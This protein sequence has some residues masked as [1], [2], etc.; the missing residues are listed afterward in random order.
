ML[1]RSPLL[2]LDSGF[3]SSIPLVGPPCLW[4]RCSIIDRCWSRTEILLASCSRIAGS[5]VVNPGDKQAIPTSC[6]RWLPPAV[7]APPVVLGACPTPAVLLRL[8]F[9]GRCRA[10]GGPEA[11]GEAG[12]FLTTILGRGEPA[13]KSM[14]VSN[15]SGRNPT[16]L[17]QSGMKWEMVL[18]IRTLASAHPGQFSSGS[19]CSCSSSQV[20]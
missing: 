18:M 14:A 3:P 15:D 20:R 8:S 16:F 11:M 19:S 6:M 12:S 10:D 17:I 13:L 4:R 5:W 7:S 9:G 1:D 2:L